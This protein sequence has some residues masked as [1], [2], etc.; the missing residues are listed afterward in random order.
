LSRF[1]LLLLHH[2]ILVLLVNP[3]ARHYTSSKSNTLTIFWLRSNLRRDTA[4][5]VALQICYRDYFVPPL[6]LVLRHSCNALKSAM[7]A[8]TRVIPSLHRDYFS[9]K[10]PGRLPD[11]SSGNATS[12]YC[13]AVSCY[14]CPKCSLYQDFRRARKS[15]AALPCNRPVAAKHMLFCPSGLSRL[16]K[17]SYIRKSSSFIGTLQSRQIKS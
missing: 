8:K 5:A 13:R 3:D 2:D 7:T 11:A 6:K 10:A 15:F 12:P 14:A 16:D 4:P 1:L 9:A 17:F